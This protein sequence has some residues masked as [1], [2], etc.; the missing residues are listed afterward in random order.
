MLILLL[1]VLHLLD[2]ALRWLEAWQVVSWDSESGVLRD[3]ASGLSCTV[4]D[5][6][7]TEA[8]QVNILLVLDEA[9]LH[10]L[11]SMNDSTTMLTSFLAIPVAIATSF[12]ISALVISLLLFIFILNNLKSVCKDTSFLR[13]NKIV[14]AFFA[15]KML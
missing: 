8:T 15:K 3:V 7:A 1:S 14:K 5:V 13:Y 11:P 12:M 6:E 9:L 4:L 2:E 10:L